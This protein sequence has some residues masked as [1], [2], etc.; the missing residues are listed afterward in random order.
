M[1]RCSFGLAPRWACSRGRLFDIICASGSILILRIIAKWELH[2]VRIGK[3]ISAWL[4]CVYNL[5]VH[6]LE[7][8]TDTVLD[9]HLFPM[10]V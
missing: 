6:Y 7:R 1:Q 3:E 2:K 5:R 4:Q 10:T 9:R 8:D